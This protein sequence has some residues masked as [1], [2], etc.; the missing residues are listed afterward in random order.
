MLLLIAAAFAAEPSAG[1]TNATVLVTIVDEKG[2]PVSLS[3]REGYVTTRDSKDR[4]EWSCRITG[5]DDDSGYGSYG[6]GAKWCVPQE[7]TTL[8]TVDGQQVTEWRSVQGTFVLPEKDVTWFNLRAMPGERQV[9]FPSVL[10]TSQETYSVVRTENAWTF[11]D[12]RLY[13]LVV[14]RASE[15]MVSSLASTSGQGSYVLVRDGKDLALTNRVIEPGAYTLAWRPVPPTRTS[16]LCPVVADATV[17]KGIPDKALLGDL[18]PEAA[19]CGDGEA[20]SVTVKDGILVRAKTAA[21]KVDAPPPAGVIVVANGKE[22]AVGAAIT[23]K[24][25]ED[26]SLEVRTPLASGR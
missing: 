18:S 26:L 9:V 20:M 10:R 7:L 24:P 25:G 1:P 19:T 12:G 22:V 2:E 3:W 23:V 8:T 4:Q 17:P 13:A 11:A 14:R 21:P 16:A 6:H 5:Y 15:L